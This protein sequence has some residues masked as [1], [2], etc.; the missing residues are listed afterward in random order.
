MDR[1]EI[2]KEIAR[3][4]KQILDISARDRAGRLSAQ[5]FPTATWIGGI[6]CLAYWVFGGMIEQNLY[7]WAQYVGLVLGILLVLSAALQ[8]IKWIGARRGL[9]TRN[10]EKNMMEAQALQTKRD[11]LQAQLDKK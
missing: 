10:V 6:V 1:E 3:L 7:S 4:D 8:S 2:L 5:P 11:Q 9:N